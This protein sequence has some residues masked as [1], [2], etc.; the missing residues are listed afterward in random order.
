[1]ALGSFD[2]N[3]I[4]IQTET[5]AQEAKATEKGKEKPKENMEVRVTLSLFPIKSD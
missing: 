5:K 3:I 4:E 2:L 1:M